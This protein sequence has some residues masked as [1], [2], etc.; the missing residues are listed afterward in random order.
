[1]RRAK[2]VATA[3]PA[4]R[5]EVRLRDLLAAGV[6]VVRINMSHGT[7]DEHAETI[8]TARKLAAELKRPLAILVDLCGPKI[9][10][11]KLRDGKPVE[12]KTDQAFTITTRNI[13][14]SSSMVSTSYLQL[15][16][17]VTPGNRILLA[18]G[19]L[20]LIVERV[21]GGTDVV[22]RVSNGGLLGERKGISLP[23]ARLSAPSLTEKDIVDLKFGLEQD[24]DYVALSFVRS[25]ADCLAAKAEIRKLCS[26][27]TPLIAKIEKSE[28]LEDLENIID[29]CEGVMVARGD[30]GVETPVESVPYHQ[31]RIITSANA[32]EKIVITATQMLESMTYEPRPTRA[33]ASDVA[34]AILDGTD[35]AMLSGE[36]AVGE[37]PVES[38]S[39]MS[40]II[41]FTEA[42]CSIEGRL[43]SSAV[44]ITGKEG[45]AI[46]E[47]AVFAAREMQLNMIVVLTRY[48]VMARHAA[49]IRPRE[50]I[51]AFTPFEKTCNTLAAVW[52]IEPYRVDFSG[53]SAALIA[54]VDDR[55]ISEG[56]LSKGEMSVVMAGNVPEQPGL[57]SLMKLHRIGEID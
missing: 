38:V 53:S 57:S 25:A 30:L 46:A 4:S 40:R 37:Y 3:G 14:G 49:A 51:I 7:H 19:M 16:V 20:E 50:R 33:E 56:L 1:M 10:T 8:R 52:G 6:D 54:R 23:G 22:T 31:K 43:A 17:D 44:E 2:I 29:A 12:L 11:G 13:E 27:D 34:N 36:T 47:A 32:G 42:H 39:T 41:E 21:D 18:D 35:A 15:P 45:R 26:H 5:T 9:R 48:G 24:A 28:A 55:L